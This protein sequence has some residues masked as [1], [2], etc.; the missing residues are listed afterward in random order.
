MVISL[1]FLLKLESLRFIGCDIYSKLASFI[2]DGLRVF[3]IG[4]LL[5]CER[6]SVTY[7]YL[8]GLRVYLSRNILSNLTLS[9]VFI[10]TK[11]SV[12]VFIACFLYNGMNIFVGYII[13]MLVPFLFFF[14]YESYKN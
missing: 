14:R 9:N 2:L 4:P 7:M 12:S 1:C 3:V 6:K 13:N 11:E 10:F 8:Y 5:S